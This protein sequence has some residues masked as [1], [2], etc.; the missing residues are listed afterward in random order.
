M[1]DKIRKV[2]QTSLIEGGTVNIPVL[3]RSCSS[4]CKP[5]KLH[6]LT[7]VIGF[8]MICIVCDIE[9]VIT[10]MYISLTLIYFVMFIN[11]DSTVG[12][13]CVYNRDSR[14]LWKLIRWLKHAMHHIAFLFVHLILCD[15]YVCVLTLISGNANNKPLCKQDKLMFCVTKIW[16]KLEW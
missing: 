12:F 7:V 11:Y 4:W 10:Y 13:L 3:I 5:W 6:G 8:I 16:S 15:A 1:N 9:G 2:V 14:R